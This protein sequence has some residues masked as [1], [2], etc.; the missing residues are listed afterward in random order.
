VSVFRID[1]GTGEMLGLL[2]KATVGEGGWA[3]LGEPII[4]RSEEAFSAVPEG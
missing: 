3:D 1:P 4:V 2:A